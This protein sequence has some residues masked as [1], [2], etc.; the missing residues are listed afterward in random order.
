MALGGGAFTAQNKRLPG[1]YLNFI[2]AVRATTALSDRGIAAMPFVGDWGKEDE[3]FS[4][5]AEQF[6]ENSR[7]LFGYDATHPQMTMFRELFRN[8]T[9]LYLFRL[10]SGT[11]KAANSYATAKYG[12]SRGNALTIVI[13]ENVDSEQGFEVITLLEQSEVDRQVV[14]KAA[15]LKEND[16]VTFQK[17]AE[18]TAAAGV[19]LTGGTDGQGRTGENY[20]RFLKKI[21]R[22]SFHALGCNSGEKEVVDLFVAFTKRM[23]DQVGAK[24]QTVV[25]RA[26]NADYEG[27]ISVENKLL[28][29]DESLFG[30]FSLV[31]WVT[32]AAAGCGVNQSN[33]N[34]AYDGEYEVD[35][36][37]TQLQLEDGLKAGKFLLHQVGEEVRVLEDINTF[38]RVTQEKSE[39]FSSNQT[40]RVLD[41]IGNDIAALFQSKYFG[42]MPNDAAGRISLWNDIV[43]HHQELESIRAIENFQPDLVTVEPGE[44]KKSVV[45][46]DYVTPVNAM[47]QLYMTVIVQ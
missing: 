40:I 26:E 11:V 33:T 14:K 7:Q 44:S 12:G 21:E 37:Y 24:F 20:Q 13:R 46:A 16:Y 18:L 4:V 41:Q 30:E 42:R 3:V 29:V 23:R 6:Q 31:Y 8:A 34:K 39:D 25:Y 22:Y 36:D 10:N 35:T 47:A 38:V 19:P 32:G 17:D 45:I 28:N 43:K 9:K 2:S 27:V 15:E 1:A 5:T